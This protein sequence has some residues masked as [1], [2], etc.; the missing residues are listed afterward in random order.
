M[1]KEI[2]YLDNDIIIKTIYRK[3]GLINVQ[4]LIEKTLCID[5]LL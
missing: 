5:Y 1:A 2:I 4:G 3:L